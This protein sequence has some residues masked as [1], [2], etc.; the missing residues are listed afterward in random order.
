MVN[1]EFN[2]F[3]R[4]AEL[5]ALLGQYA[6]EF[7]SLVSVE[8]CGSSHEGR[9]IWVATVTSQTHGRHD[10][11]P[12]IWLD[13]NIHSVELTAST[14]CLYQLHQLVTGYGDDPEITH[15]LNTRTFYICPRVNPDGAEAALADSP[16]FVRS[17]MRL[18]PFEYEPLD[19]LDPQDV[20]G[21]GRILF[22]R[23]PDP[24]G[25]WTPHPDDP[26]LMVRRDPASYEGDF[27]RLYREGRIRNFD[28]AKVV[29]NAPAEGLDLNRN[30]PANWA[31]E[32]KQ[33][34]A[35]SAPLSE[36][37][38]RAVGDFIVAHPNIFLAIAGH[39]FSGVLLRASTQVA[40]TSLPAGDLAVYE[41]MGRKGTELTGYPAISVFHDFKYDPS[42][43]LHG[44]MDWLYEHLGIFWWTPEYWAPHRAAGVDVNHYFKWF[45]EHPAEDD[46]KMLRWA[47][48]ASARDLYVDWY[49]FDHPE[50]GRV[51]LGGWDILHSFHNPPPELLEKEVALFPPWLNWMALLSPLLEIDKLTADHAGGDVYKL[52]AVVDN[53]GY[54]PTSGSFKAVDNKA[55]GNVIVELR[56]PD[57]AR[58]LHGKLREDVGQL[59]GRSL[60]PATQVFIGTGFMPGDRM[61]DRAVLE[62]VLCAPGGSVVELVASHPRSGRASASIVLGQEGDKE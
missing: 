40:D 33:Q 61:D 17:S 19:G 39:T 37:E 28:G 30:F 9:Q 14:V 55:V 24:K 29:H 57:N 45:L 51:E 23:V 42:E 5:G 41:A 49:A 59:H 38:T 7:P 53:A 27:Y 2:R 50:L 60:I 4:H 10:T 31:P 8:S 16:R 11:K 22:M 12:A 58:L 54:L 34:G 18:Y 46:L 13:G 6:S 44:G 20:D 36:P 32:G 26:R 35:G 62:W 25:H 1:T 21:D 3:Y 48:E 47:D 52:R 15:L 56:L 43:T